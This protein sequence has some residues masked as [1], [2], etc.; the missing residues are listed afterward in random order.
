M[1]ANTIFL[2]D[3]LALSM[4]LY[5]TAYLLYGRFKHR[6]FVGE[7]MPGTSGH[8]AFLKLVKSNK[9]LAVSIIVILFFI[10]NVI[11]DVR[12]ILGRPSSHSILVV[13]PIMIALTYIIA[14]LLLPKILLGKK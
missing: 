13:V 9:Y 6:P 2:I 10:L 14:T 11:F 8:K 12:R 7:H 4:A 1:N 3:A 5:F